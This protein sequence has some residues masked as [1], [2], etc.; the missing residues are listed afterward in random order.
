MYQPPIRPNEIY[1]Y[2]IK[3]RSGRYPWGSGERPYQDTDKDKKNIK[4]KKGTHVSR[5][6]LTENENIPNVRKYVSMQDV[7]EEIW[8]RIMKDGYSK[9]G[10]E[11]LYSKKYETLRDVKIASVKTAKKEYDKWY[12][13]HKSALS[14][15][16]PI[17]IE[18][19]SES[20]GGVKTGD[21]KEDFFKQL[22]MMNIVNKS[23]LDHMKRKGY[24]GLKDVY[25][26]KTGGDKSIII[27]DPDNTLDL[28][29]QY[30]IKLG[31]QS[32]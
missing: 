9:K 4:L 18:D 14:I 11:Y 17:I 20:T 30:R 25:G 2:G 27:L 28:K 32:S 7:P 8:M 5:L 12:D 31:G 29:E 26:V 3:R 10:Y 23:Y 16:L 24:D 21:Q 6:S 13:A 1:H 15:N 22:G 19:W